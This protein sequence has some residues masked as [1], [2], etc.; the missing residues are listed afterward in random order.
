MEPREDL[1]QLREL[2]LR[3][4]WRVLPAQFEQLYV[5]DIAEAMQGLE[6]TQMLRV[7]QELPA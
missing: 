2:I 7:F 6:P 5:Q 1:L 4:D 3:E